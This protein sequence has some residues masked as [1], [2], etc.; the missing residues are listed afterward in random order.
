[1]LDNPSYIVLAVSSSPSRGALFTLTCCQLM[2]D[3]GSGIGVL[4]FSVQFGTFR[5]GLC[6]F[7]TAVSRI[8]I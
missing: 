2:H 3:G 7:V 1:M 4:R 6:P 8:D 5:L